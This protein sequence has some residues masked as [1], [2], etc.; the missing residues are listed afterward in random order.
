[1]PP[2]I[3]F[4]TPTSRST[5]FTEHA[6]SV[7]RSVAL[8]ANNGVTCAISGADGYDVAQQRDFIATE[9]LQSGFSHLLFND[10]DI[11]FPP[12]LPLKLLS[13]D[14][15]LIGAVYPFRHFNISKLERL[16]KAGV[17][18]DKALSYAHDFAGLW[19]NVKFIKGLGVV[20]AIGAGFMLIR[21]EVFD[22][23]EKECGAP[24]YTPHAR[25]V[26]VKRFFPWERDKDGNLIPEDW[27]FCFRWRK[28][29]GEVWAY[30]DAEMQHVG[31]YAHSCN[32]LEASKALA[33]LK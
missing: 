19:G 16:I 6:N 11:G 24:S 28:V 22:K 14:K 29:G 23:I 21:R 31:S 32:A 13:L 9:F 17:P 30:A 1:M 4:G 7:A 26:P 3:F 27:G 25:T 33:A 5:E 8:L 10:S 20:D 12:A 2:S 18:G 15:P